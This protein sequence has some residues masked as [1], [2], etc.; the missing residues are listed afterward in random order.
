VFLFLAGIASAHGVHIAASVDGKTIHGRATFQGGTPMKNVSVTAHDAAD[1][2][3]TQTKTDDDGQFSLEAAWRCDYH[4][5]VETADGHGGDCIVKASLLPSNLPARE[6]LPSAEDS[7]AKHGHSHAAPDT[8]DENPW[9]VEQIRN[10]QAKLNI[11]Q[12]KLDAQNQSL[13]VRDILGGIGY[14]LGVFG[15]YAIA[16][17]YFK[18]RSA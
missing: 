4:L 5:E 6:N 10:I 2:V 12:E 18:K 14:I 9:T 7:A 3:L 17:N 11:L 1:Q 8:G 15:L 16:V 13:R